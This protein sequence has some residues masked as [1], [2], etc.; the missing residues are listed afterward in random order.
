MCR[1]YL[2]PAGKVTMSPALMET[3]SPPVGVTVHSAPHK[4]HGLTKGIGVLSLGESPPVTVSV[5][6]ARNRQ[7][8]ELW[9]DV[10]SLGFGFRWLGLAPSANWCWEGAA[11]RAITVCQGAKLAGVFFGIWGSRAKRIGGP[12]ACDQQASL[13]LS[14]GPRELGH[15]APPAFIV[16]KA[17]RSS[18]HRVVLASSSPRCAECH[19]GSRK[20]D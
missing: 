10:P 9:N 7:G 18:A 16:L 15:V 3:G 11:N 19:Q 8:L 12:T 17:Q 20:E 6:S 2:I 4:Q 1:A 5:H 14:V 13:V